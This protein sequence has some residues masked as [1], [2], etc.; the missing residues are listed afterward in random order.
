MR[1]M[2]NAD[3]TMKVRQ[4]LNSICAPEDL[5]KNKTLQITLDI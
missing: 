1:K 5:I 2:T 3:A 4:E